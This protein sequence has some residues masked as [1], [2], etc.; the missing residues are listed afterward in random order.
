MKTLTRKKGHASTSK[1]GKRIDIRLTA[2]D[3]SLLQRAASY[4]GNNLSAFIIMSLKNVASQLIREHE[5][6]TLTQ[7]DQDLF[8]RTIASSPAPNQRLKEAFEAHRRN[9]LG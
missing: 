5:I 8:V 3:K 1:K 4:V 6:I 7:R 2:E 9:T